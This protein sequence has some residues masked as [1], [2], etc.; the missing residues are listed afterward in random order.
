L[1]MVPEIEIVGYEFI[2]NRLCMR[3]RRHILSFL[4]GGGYD[5]LKVEHYR[6]SLALIY[7][8]ASL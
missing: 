4:I 1:R 3:L 7:S 2:I 8:E 6:V 5:I